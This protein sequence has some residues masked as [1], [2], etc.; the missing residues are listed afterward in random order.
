MTKEQSCEWI[1]N[2]FFGDLT[3]EE[4]KENL[5]SMVDRI[6]RS[7]SQEIDGIYKASNDEC[8]KERENRFPIKDK[9]CENCKH[10]KDKKCLL[11]PYGGWD[12][13]NDSPC[14]YEY[15]ETKNNFFCNRWESK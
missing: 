6:Y 9:N 14:D 12:N 8:N 5:K 10:L 7:F 15:I 11:L 1:D 13:Y 2:T 4:M 3:E